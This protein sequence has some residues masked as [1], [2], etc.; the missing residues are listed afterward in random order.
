MKKLILLC[1]MGLLCLPISTTTAQVA[2]SPGADFLHRS[3]PSVSFG[4][5]DTH[6]GGETRSDTLPENSGLVDHSGQGQKG[7]GSSASRD[8]QENPMLFYLQVKSDIPPN[9]LRI[10]FLEGVIDTGTA[11]PRLYEATEQ[12]QPGSMWDGGFGAEWARLRIPSKQAG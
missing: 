3:G 8:I 10:T 6:R 7:E 1:F 2:D 5:G 9:N 4:L 11:M 12:F